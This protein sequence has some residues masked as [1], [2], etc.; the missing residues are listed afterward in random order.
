M[1]DYMY[2][3][4]IS[5]LVLLEV[6]TDQFSWLL[7]TCDKAILRNNGRFYWKERGKMQAE[8]FFQWVTNRTQDLDEGRERARGLASDFRRTF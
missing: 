4:P 5:N 6:A 7:R 3:P 2:D 8:R 1:A